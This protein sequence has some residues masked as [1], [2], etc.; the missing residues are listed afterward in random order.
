MSL[1]KLLFSKKVY[2]EFQ[3]WK[4][5]KTAIQSPS[6][7]RIINK[8]G[9]K[10]KWSGKLYI[11]WDIPNEHRT[12]RDETAGFAFNLIVN[13]IGRPSKV[14]VELG[15]NDIADWK[16]KITYSKFYYII[17]PHFN[18]FK[19]SKVIFN[20]IAFIIATLSLIYFIF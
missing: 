20:Y 2:K 18:Y 9:F 8:Y 3:E 13:K 17:Y 11:E 7:I 16:T 12:N 10:Q 6:T 19:F 15:L 1:L 5:Y 4:D 14:L